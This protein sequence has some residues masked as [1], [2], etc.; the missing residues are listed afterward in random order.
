MMTDRLAAAYWTPIKELAR[1]ARNPRKNESAIPE[2]ARS[3]RKY[4]FVAPVVVWQSRSQIIA[5]HTRIAALES[6]LSQ[7]RA[8][9]PRDAPGAGL[10]PVRFHEFADES[11]AAAYALADNKLGELADW[12]EDVLGQI[13]GELRS[14]DETL[15]AH[16]GFGDAE[17]EALIRQASDS[18]PVQGTGEDPGAQ[19]DRATELQEKWRTAPGQL[20]EISSATV[21]GRAHRLLCGDSRRAEDALRVM[22]GDKARWCW[23]A[24]PSTRRRSSSSSSPSACRGRSRSAS[25]VTA[26]AIP[27]LPAPAWPSRCPT[28]RSRGNRSRRLVAWPG[29]CRLRR[30]HLW[31]APKIPQRLSDDELTGKVMRVGYARCVTR[32]APLATCYPVL[33]RERNNSP[34]FVS[35][36]WRRGD[37]SNVAVG[38]PASAPQ[39][40]GRGLPRGT[41]PVPRPS[42]C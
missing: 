22:D 42:P 5:G 37:P 36:A 27:T 25:S 39:R 11:E 19:L 40:R 16:T 4:G 7:D 15:L 35:R 2:V 21:P 14:I 6:L 10:V 20:W 23:T 29:L 32:P 31:A 9:V 3:I 17:I 33:S 1:W 18:G 12:D 24:L 34:G 38:A 26:W 30:P 8:F 13:L 41:G 28:S